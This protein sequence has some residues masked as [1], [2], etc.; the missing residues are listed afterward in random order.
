MGTRYYDDYGTKNAA[1]E[2]AFDVLAYGESPGWCGR[3][4]EDLHAVEEALK[5]FNITYHCD[6]TGTWRPRGE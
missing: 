1:A 4:L 5:P 2:I 3:T 6:M